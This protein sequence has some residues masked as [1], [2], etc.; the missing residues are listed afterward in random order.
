[1]TKLKPREKT[2]SGVYSKG[3]SIQAHIP[4]QNNA[5]GLFENLL[6]KNFP[7]Q[8]AISFDA[9]QSETT[10]LVVSQYKQKVLYCTNGHEFY[11]GEL[12]AD[13]LPHGKGSMHKCCSEGLMDT[14]KGFEDY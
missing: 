13:N 14:R 6:S 7:I 5:S 12:N 9:E 2:V 10:S 8:N 1:M 4:V 11:R 3:S